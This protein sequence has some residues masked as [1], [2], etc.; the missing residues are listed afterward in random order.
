MSKQKAPCE[1][2]QKGQTD[3][4]FKCGNQQCEKIKC[5]NHTFD[6]HYTKKNEL[7]CSLCYNTCKKCRQN[8]QN[9]CKKCKIQMCNEF[10]CTNCIYKYNNTRIALCTTCKECSKCEKKINQYEI[11]DLC[12][13]IICKKCWIECA[14]KKKHLLCPCSTSEGQCYSH[15]TEYNKCDICKKNYVEDCK[16]SFKCD[17]CDESTACISC[18][19]KK[20]GLCFYHLSQKHI[21]KC[22][23]A[24]ELNN[25]CEFDIKAHKEALIKEL[26]N[27]DIKKKTIKLWIDN[28]FGEEE[29]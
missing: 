14:C 10:E 17:K 28:Y 20:E 1:N 3:K 4:C 21:D 18:G 13:N 11:C 27:E 23:D 22:I 26:L 16:C 24:I 12:D 19:S 8:E 2:C 29:N 5:I 6:K 25:Q 9:K 7:I 15:N